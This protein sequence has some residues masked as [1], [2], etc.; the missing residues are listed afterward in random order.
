[1]TVK[2]LINKQFEIEGID[3]DFERMSASG[4]V[5]I[6]KK[7]PVEWYNV[8]RFSSEAKYAE[9]KTLC[10]QHISAQEFMHIDFKYGMTF[11]Y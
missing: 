11:K 1:M 4:M 6:G 7:N 9:W 8:Y 2:Q 10:L 5:D 3:Y